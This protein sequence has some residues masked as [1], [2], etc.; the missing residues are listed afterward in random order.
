VS[1]QFWKR[2]DG[3]DGIVQTTNSA[4]TSGQFRMTAETTSE[5]PTSPA[6]RRTRKR[7][8]PSSTDA[9]PLQSGQGQ[10]EFE[11]SAQSAAEHHQQT[12]SQFALDPGMQTFAGS[13]GHAGMSGEDGDDH[14]QQGRSPA[15]SRPVNPSKRAEQNRKAQRAFRERRDA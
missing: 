14:S 6:N 8:S 1:E 13:D 11:T 12:T 5:S 2:D 10:Y 9:S 15:N 7:K 4:D 3:L